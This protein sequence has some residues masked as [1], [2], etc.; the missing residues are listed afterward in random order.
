[1]PSF[2]FG[3]LDLGLVISDLN[4]VLVLRIIWSCLHHCI[5]LVSYLF[6]KIKLYY[7][8]QSYQVIE[9]KKLKFTYWYAY[10]I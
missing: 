3:G 4:L 1:V 10:A 8:N 2:S 6:H 9:I 7:N 5:R